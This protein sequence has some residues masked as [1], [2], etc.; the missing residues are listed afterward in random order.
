[1]FCIPTVMGHRPKPFPGSNST[2]A[3]IHNSWNILYIK[4]TNWWRFGRPPWLTI[5]SP[6]PSYRQVDHGRGHVFCILPEPRNPHQASTNHTPVQKSQEYTKL[7]PLQP[8]ITLSI[9]WSLGARQVLQRVLWSSI[10]SYQLL[11]RQPLSGIVTRSINLHWTLGRICLVI[12]RAR[13]LTPSSCRPSSMMSYII[14]VIHN[15][16]SSWVLSP[17]SRGGRQDRIHIH[18]FRSN[19]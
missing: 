17:S 15:P 18:T 4:K 3:K 13:P 8:L 6:G 5:K 11:D 7:M 1:M 16:A 14:N 10:N 9:Y 19:C 12:C 2:G